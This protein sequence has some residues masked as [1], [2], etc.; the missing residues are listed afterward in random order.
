MKNI[1]YRKGLIVRIVHPAGGLLHKKRYGAVVS[2]PTRIMRGATTS[3]NG[4]NLRRGARA[5]LDDMSA[6]PN[7]IPTLPKSNPVCL[8]LLY[9]ILAEESSGA[10]VDSARRICSLI[11]LASQKLYN[12]QQASE[13]HLLSCEMESRVALS[14]PSMTLRQREAL[15]ATQVQFLVPP[16]PSIFLATATQVLTKDVKSYQISLKSSLI[17]FLAVDSLYKLPFANTPPRF[18]T[19]GDP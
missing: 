1:Q 12:F 2:C 17:H 18:S 14:C 6:S 8:R 15:E 3:T 9:L 16:L 19:H 7:W 10:A 13:K 11:L 4:C 5:L